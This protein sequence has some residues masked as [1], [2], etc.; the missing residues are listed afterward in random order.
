MVDTVVNITNIGQHALDISVL[1]TSPVCICARLAMRVCRGPLPEGHP[2]P[3]TIYFCVDHDI[4]LAASGMQ[5]TP[6][7]QSYAFTDKPA[8]LLDAHRAPNEWFASACRMPNLLVQGDPLALRP[9]ACARFAAELAKAAVPRGVRAAPQLRFSRT[10]TACLPNLLGRAVVL[11]GSHET[12]DRL[13]AHIRPEGMVKGDGAMDRHGKYTQVHE[14]PS[15]ALSVSVDGGRRMAS[16]AHLYQHVVVSPGSVRAGEYDTVV[17]MPDVPEPIARAVCH[18]ARYMVIGVGHSPVA[19]I[20]EA[21]GAGS[22][23]A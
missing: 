4:A 17:V 3:G 18:R 16:R 22:S 19:Y 2:A 12:R 8:V 14:T 5:R 11:C 23:L 7:L 20:S 21:C 1:G 13:Y 15:S 10:V 6:V 9:K